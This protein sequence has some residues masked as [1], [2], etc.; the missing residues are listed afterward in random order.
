MKSTDLRMGN[1]VQ[2]KEHLKGE[3]AK[4][5]YINTDKLPLLDFSEIVL[6]C[7]DQIHLN[8]EK[9]EIEFDYTEIE[10]ILLNEKWLEKFGF[11]KVTNLNPKI[12]N[13]EYMYRKDGYHL[14]S[15]FLFHFMSGNKKINFVHEL[16]NSYK[17]NIGEE[18]SL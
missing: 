14:G 9:E 6:I 3:I 16:Q 18:L 15:D 12:R 7:K 13:Y 1:F 17:E 8:I 4:D 10:P 2:I 11:D 5:C